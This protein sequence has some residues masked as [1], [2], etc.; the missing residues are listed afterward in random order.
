M[1]FELYSVTIGAMVQA[2]RVTKKKVDRATKSHKSVIFH[3][4]GR[5]SLINQFDAKVARWVMSTT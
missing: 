2:G 1:S 4:F 3:L 5:K